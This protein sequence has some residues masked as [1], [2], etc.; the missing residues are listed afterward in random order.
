[1]DICWDFVCVSSCYFIRIS[2][3]ISYFTQNLKIERMMKFEK[4]SFLVCMIATVFLFISCNKIYDNTKQSN[5][6]EN[7]NYSYEYS[8]KENLKQL[9]M[10][11]EELYYN[12]EKENTTPITCGTIDGKIISMANKN[13]IPKENNQSNFGKGYV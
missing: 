9:V 5:I 11:N 3:Y 10:V 12:T 4:I 13:E 7:N 1:M 2:F 8:N 6:K